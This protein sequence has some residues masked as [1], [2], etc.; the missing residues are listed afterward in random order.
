MY[1]PCVSQNKSAGK[2]G[3][4]FGRGIPAHCV[5]RFNTI[6]VM[7]LHGLQLNHLSRIQRDAGGVSRKR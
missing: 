1:L 5:V 2:N 6:G 4:S 7:C 3:T